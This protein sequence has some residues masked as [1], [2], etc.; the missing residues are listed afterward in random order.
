MPPLVAQASRGV[1][2]YRSACEKEV[3]FVKADRPT[4]PKSINKEVTM[5]K[6][7]TIIALVVAAF[8][9]LAVPALA[10]NGLR[11]DYTVSGACQGCHTNG[12]FGAPAVYP[13]W[14]LTKHA[15]DRTSRG[16]HTLVGGGCGCHISNLDPSK[17]NPADLPAAAPTAAQASGSAAFSEGFIG[18]SAC[19]YGA[20]PVSTLDGRDTADTAHNAPFAEM[21]NADICGQCHSRGSYT[22]AQIPVLPAGTMIQPMYA[23]GYPMLGSPAASPAT[24]WTPAAPL[25]QYLTIPHT[26][27]VSWATPAPVATPLNQLQTYWQTTDGTQTLWQQLG[28]DGSAAQ[29]PE[30][31]NEGHA[32]S[33]TVLGPN[34]QAECLKCHS[35]DYRNAPDNAKPTGAEAK[36]AITCTGCHTPHDAGTAKGVWDSEFDTQL[37]GNPK[38]PSDLCSTC[39]N[40]EIPEGSTAS[41]GATVH[42]PMKEM[43]DGYGAID[44]ESVPSVH[45]G[46]CIQCHMPPTS[47]GRGSTQLG[48]N[49]TFNIITPETAVDASPI[50]VSTATAISTVGSVTTTTLTVTQDSMPYSACSTCHDNNVKATPQPVATATTGAGTD[51]VT[52][53]IT[54]NKAGGDKGLW[55]QDTID[56]R[57]AW[58]KAKIVDIN[59]AIEAAAGRLGY[60]A[61]VTPAKTATMVAHDALVV[62]PAAKRTTDQTTFLKAFTNVGYVA[63]EGSFGI[64]NWA[65]SRAI[66]NTA[67]AEAQAVKTAPKPWRVTFKLSKAK[68]SVNHTVKFSGTVKTSAMAP[69]TGLVTIQKK[70]S[71]HWKAWK[72]AKLNSTG[73]FAKTVKMTNKG[74]FYFR[75]LMPAHAG[76]LVKASTSHKLVVK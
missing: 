20:E 22:V 73:G 6:R 67:L 44:V 31:K 24:G 37:V 69:G 7:V 75:A 47:Y 34:P 46:K 55:L 51:A 15:A 18:C 61:T 63:G 3:I 33:L 70:V 74:T 1:F 8:L 50:P 54:Q 14:A 57:Q 45:K 25:S 10:W 26:G 13:A 19:H 36:Y 30:W 49:H 17:V 35:A 64:H 29:Y 4:H 41:P 12:T 38:N 68:V 9:V 53:T 66:A 60:V 58:T 48:G 52:K 56:Q 11:G 21:A 59:A 72:T 71:G 32:N 27:P 28:H 5:F 43:M 16:T 42:H 62:I 40:G 39:H 2:E 65:Y 76:N 23:V